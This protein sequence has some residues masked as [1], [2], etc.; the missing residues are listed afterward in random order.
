M[1]VPFTLQPTLPPHATYDTEDESIAK[2]DDSSKISTGNPGFM[3]KG[4]TNMGKG[5]SWI[6]FFNIPS[7]GGECMFS[8]R[9]A[10][11]SSSDRPCDVTVNGVSAGSLP[12]PPT[13]SWIDWQYESINANCISGMNTIR[14]KSTSRSGGANI[15]SLSLSSDP[16][17]APPTPPPVSMLVNSF[18][19]S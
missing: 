5:G 9:Y 18:V 16:S 15:D 7:S 12:F 2:F 10:N 1:S 14:I 4:Y 13:D 8:F 3:G 6:E 19:F 17:L 11:G